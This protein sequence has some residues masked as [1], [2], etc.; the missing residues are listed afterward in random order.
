MLRDL[1]L[2]CQHLLLLLV[3]DLGLLRQL[4][5]QFLSGSTSIVL[6][7]TLTLI[8]LLDHVIH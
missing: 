4:V 6:E 1:F 3:D 2:Q 8:L 7:A 5:H